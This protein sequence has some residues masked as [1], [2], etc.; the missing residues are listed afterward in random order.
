MLL[1]SPEAVLPTCYWLLKCLSNDV[2]LAAVYIDMFADQ[3]ASNLLKSSKDKVRE[4]AALLF[5]SL[6]STPRSIEDAT[7]AAEI[8]TKPLTAGRYTQAD[9]RVGV[10]QS[11]GQCARRAWQ[12]VGVVGGDLACSAEDDSQGDA[13]GACQRSTQRYWQPCQRCN[14]VS[15][16]GRG[17]C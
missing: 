14:R 11:A 12:R 10:L 6:A 7:K 5:E 16:H 4:T 8:A 9:H 17:W 13:G 1:R 2:D 3:I 15:A